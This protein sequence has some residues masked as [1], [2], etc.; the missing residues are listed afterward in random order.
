MAEERLHQPLFGLHRIEWPED[1]AVEFRLP[2]GEMIA[3]LR[4]AGFEV[5]SLTEV[6]VPEG[7]TSRL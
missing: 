2:H 3:L 5:E 7:S 1:E 6:Q 4:D